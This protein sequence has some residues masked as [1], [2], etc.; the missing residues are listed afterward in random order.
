L[1]NLFA[2]AK[3]L[4]QLDLLD[5]RFEALEKNA[6]AGLENLKSINLNHYQLTFFDQDTFKGLEKLSNLNISK[7]KILEIFYS[8]Q[9]RRFVRQNFEIKRLK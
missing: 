7:N 9:N 4:K 3:N 5:N 6:F 1:P 2:D 8:C